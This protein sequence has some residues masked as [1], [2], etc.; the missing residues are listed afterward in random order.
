M[1]VVAADGQCGESLLVGRVGGGEEDVIVPDDGRGVACGDGG[2]AEGILIRAELDGALGGCGTG[3][4]GAGVAMGRRYVAPVC[5]GWVG[6]GG[7]G[8]SRGGGVRLGR[9][10]EEK[11][12]HRPKSGLVEGEHYRR[13][14]VR[15]DWVVGFVG[16]GEAWC[17]YGTLFL[18]WPVVGMGWVCGGLGGL[19]AVRRRG[20]GAKKR[21]HICRFR[22]KMS[23]LGNFHFGDSKYAT[24]RVLVD[25]DGDY[26]WYV[27]LTEG[28]G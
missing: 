28:N 25:G 26:G 21:L 14:L 16:G 13:D 11:Q 23:K 20:E 9:G 10:Q 6:V 1:A 5:G 3:A 12:E 19:M 15:R 22:G 18:A 24:T 17:G 7:W 4:G 2:F 8:A 27:L